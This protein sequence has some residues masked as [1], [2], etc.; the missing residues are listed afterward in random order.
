MTSS[1]VTLESFEIDDPADIEQSAEYNRGLA[2]G[3]AQAEASQNADLA[4]SV[5]RI[6]SSLTDM[7]FGYEEARLHVL[8]RLRPLLRQ[9]SE[10]ILPIIARETFGT[11]LIDVIEVEFQT[12]ASAPIMISV[13]RDLVE[14]LNSTV[15]GDLFTFVA[16][17]TLDVGQALLCQDNT[18]ILLDLP[19]LTLALQSALNGLERPERIQSHG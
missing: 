7:A 11:H 1:V 3:L 16:D 2:D 18:H 13:A 17:Q 6:S 4:R 10:A 19:A 8:E 15:T 5:E 14:T 9:T 12:A